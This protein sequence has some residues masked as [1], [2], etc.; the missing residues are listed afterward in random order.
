M[1]LE[2]YFVNVTENWFVRESVVTHGLSFIK[3]IMLAKRIHSLPGYPV[4]AVS[5]STS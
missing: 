4:R 1:Q 5:T 2:Q 3:E